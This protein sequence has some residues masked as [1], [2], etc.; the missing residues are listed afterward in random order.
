MGFDWVPLI[1]EGSSAKTHTFLNISVC[2]FW[3][4]KIAQTTTNMIFWKFGKKWGASLST[5]PVKLTFWVLVEGPWP[6]VGIGTCSTGEFRIKEGST[7]QL[8]SKPF[9]DS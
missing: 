1:I 8:V 9:K 7:K 4:P 6:Y 5:K 3:V 2:E